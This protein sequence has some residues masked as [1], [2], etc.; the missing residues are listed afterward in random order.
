[1]MGMGLEQSYNDEPQA[2]KKEMIFLWDGKGG[3]G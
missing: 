3:A 2:E 1:M